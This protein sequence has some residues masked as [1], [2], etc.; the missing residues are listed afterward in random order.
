MSE[1]RL[2]ELL[3][4]SVQHES[5]PDLADAAWER[6]QR[7]R[8]RSRFA[9]VAGSVAAVVVLVGG[10]SVLQRP[11][12]VPRPMPAPGA[13]SQSG[14]PD[15]DLDGTPVWW[16]PAGADE[17]ALPA[18][19]RSLT[20]L[21]ETIDL[22]AD[23]PD[24][25]ATPLDQALAAFAVLDDEGVQRLLLVGTDGSYRAL[26]VSGLDQ[27]T[28]PNGY[29]LDPESVS[30]LSPDGRTLLFPQDGHL[31]LYELPS[32]E[33]RR[34]ETGSRVTAFA[35][36]VSSEQIHLPRTSAG[37]S[38][39]VL[40]LDGHL[41]GSMDLHPVTQGLPLG[42]AEPFGLMR[43]NPERSVVAQSWSVGAHA[44]APPDAF[45]DPEVLV[46]TPG[47]PSLI[48]A[49]PGSSS[50]QPVRWKQ[51]CPAVGWLDDDTV[52]YESRKAVPQL[53]AWRIG[54]HDFHTVTTITGFTAGLE[55][56]TASWADLAAER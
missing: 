26:D 23:A 2:R 51:C 32:N 16:A 13:N 20:R 9:V 7:S 47:D 50:G 22:S 54:T 21:P 55:S 17:A 25:A 27:V 38:G 41:V 15:A 3:H 46:V 4:E 52:V 48:L 34:V 43:A 19:D 18:I 40:D 8:R 12:S 30:M 42:Q 35:T 39:P 37:G 49:L 31:E 1:Q 29:R 44:P 45:Q 11:D 5:G 53:I 14:S 24:I 36:W 6:A 33:W 28:K 56:Y 10:F